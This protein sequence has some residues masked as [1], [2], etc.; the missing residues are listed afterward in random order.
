C[1]P[2]RSDAIFAGPPALDRWLSGDKDDT[3][4]V[5]IS[6][7]T[8]YPDMQDPRQG[9]RCVIERTA[10]A[11]RAGLDSLFVGDQHASPTPYYQ[12]TPI[13]GRMLAECSA[14]LGGRQ[15]VLPVWPTV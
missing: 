4:R 14:A 12:N 6:L 7:T 11:R 15:I 5:G 9:A 3:M 13:H 1:H 8:N 2:A 10:A